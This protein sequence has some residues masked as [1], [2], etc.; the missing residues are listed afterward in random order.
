MK[1]TRLAALMMMVW[2][3]CATATTPSVCSIDAWSTDKDPKGLNVRAAPAPDAAVVAILPPPNNGIA[4]EMHVIGAQ[5]GWFRIDRAGF[6]DYPGEVSAKQVFSGQGWVFGGRIGF[7]VNNFNL[8][9]GPGAQARTIAT[10]SSDTSGPDSFVVRRVLDCQG[11]RAEVD[12]TFNGKSLHG[13]ASGL[14][15]NQVTTCP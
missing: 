6:E 11:D 13:W 5:A 14:C 7:L 8:K 10:L 9:D 4:V 3:A 15:S 1:I 12:G 2:P